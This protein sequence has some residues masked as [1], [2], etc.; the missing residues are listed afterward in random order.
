MRIKKSIQLTTKPLEDLITQ[1][2]S[3]DFRLNDPAWEDLNTGDI[4]E[5]WEDFSGWDKTP[6]NN[7][8][9]INARIEDIIHAHTFYELIDK[10]P[11][12]FSETASKSEI[13]DN[14]RQWWT[15]EKEEKSGVLG[16]KVRKI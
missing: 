13:I 9:K 4:I 5:F 16:L 8:R 14:L 11:K 15:P 12:T 3:V 10:L 6:Q 2:N 1:G 7:A